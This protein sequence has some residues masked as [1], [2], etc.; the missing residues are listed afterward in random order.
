LVVAVVPL[1]KTKLRAQHF[2][3]VGIFGRTKR[4]KTIDDPILDKLKRF[5]LSVELDFGCL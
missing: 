1:D 4:T 5:D 3:I 2:P